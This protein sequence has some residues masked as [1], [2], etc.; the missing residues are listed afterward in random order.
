MTDKK[1]VHQIHECAQVFKQEFENDYL[2]IV[3]V[4]HQYDNIDSG[5]LPQYRVHVTIEDEWK[6]EYE[7]SY[8][9]PVAE[10]GRS[11]GLF[12]FDTVTKWEDNQ[13]TLRF[14]YNPQ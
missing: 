2:N 9:Y 6:S 13:I 5:P 1:P 8:T 4:F 10:F 7:P 11:L 3:G 12:L 14:G